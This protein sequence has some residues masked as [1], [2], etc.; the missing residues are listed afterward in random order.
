M[1]PVR[2]TLLRFFTHHR[3]ERGTRQI[4]GRVASL[5]EV[6]TGFH[7]ELT[8]RENIYLNGA[9]LGMR[10]AR[11]EEVRRDRR[12]CRGGA[13][14]GHAGQAI[15]YRECMSACVRGRGAFGAGD[16]DCRRSARRGRRRFPEEM[17]WEDGSREADGPCCS[18]AIIWAR[19]KNCAQMV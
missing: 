10:R 3:A 19:F 4:R 5:L 8:G 14:S 16:F 12:L 2:S 18:L 15:F 9:I 13:I 17:S 1:A 7:P 11:S 6:G